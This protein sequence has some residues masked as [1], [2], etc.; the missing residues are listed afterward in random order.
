VKLTYEIKTLNEFKGLPLISKIGIILFF[1]GVIGGGIVIFS[2]VFNFQI[3]GL[4]LHHD[5]IFYLFGMAFIG[6]FTAILFDKDRKKRTKIGKMGP[7]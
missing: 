7:N 3:A 6:F 4:T 1:V 5:Y 2:K